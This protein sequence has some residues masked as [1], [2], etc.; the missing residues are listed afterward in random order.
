MTPFPKTKEE[1]IDIIRECLYSRD[2]WSNGIDIETFPDGT[3]NTITGIDDWVENWT[4]TSE[5][6][7]WNTSKKKY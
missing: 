6:F 1:L 5:S 2:D 4:E 7:R 3:I